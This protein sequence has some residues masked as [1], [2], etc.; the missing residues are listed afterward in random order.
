[1]GFLSARPNAPPL[2]ETA[3]A[4]TYM[5]VCLALLMA[6]WLLR[7]WRLQAGKK[8]MTQQSNWGQ[9]RM[10]VRSLLTLAVC[11]LVPTTGIS[12]EPLAA[13]R[14]AVELSTRR[15]ELPGAVVA[16]WHDARVIYREAIGRRALRPEPEPMTLD[17]IF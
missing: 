15:G 6:F 3:I 12:Q 17:T 8:E 10:F 5:A 2:N 7:G 9:Y 11:C 14:P 1:M 4:I 13:I 16:V